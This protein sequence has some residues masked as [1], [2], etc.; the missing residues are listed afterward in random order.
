MNVALGHL[1]AQVLDRSCITLWVITFEANAIETSDKMKNVP[2]TLTFQ[3]YNIRNYQGI[4]QIIC[5][6]FGTLEFYMIF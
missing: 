1:C 5:T 3:K 4:A 2:S 6:K